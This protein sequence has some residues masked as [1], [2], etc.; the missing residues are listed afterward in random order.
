MKGFLSY[1]KQVFGFISQ[2]YFKVHIMSLNFVNSL[3]AY[4][5][6]IINQPYLNFY[7]LCILNLEANYI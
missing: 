2:K 4:I 3:L 1:V 5:M 6:G 7:L